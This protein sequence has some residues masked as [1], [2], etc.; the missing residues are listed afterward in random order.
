M[1]PVNRN[2]SCCSLENVPL[3]VLPAAAAALV[4]NLRGVLIPALGGGVTG[5]MVRGGMNVGRVTDDLSVLRPQLQGS[6]PLAAVSALVG[7]RRERERETFKLLLLDGNILQKR[8]LNYTTV[9]DKRYVVG[10][11]SYCVDT[12]YNA[13]SSYSRAWHVNVI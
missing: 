6:V 13:Y 7:G 5:G 3:T 4:Q 10:T 11:L 8:E 9:A 1:H 2:C 12:R